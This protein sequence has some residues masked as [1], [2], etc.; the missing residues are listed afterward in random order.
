MFLFFY[1]ILKQQQKKSPKKGKSST[2]GYL[3][4]DPTGD[5]DRLWNLQGESAPSI[6][7]EKKEEK[8]VTA[9]K[10]QNCPSFSKEGK[11]LTATSQ[12]KLRG[13]K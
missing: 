10:V 5:I 9:W 6:I 3:S 4:V 1:W 13:K 2:E 12:E 11:M 8:K 7:T